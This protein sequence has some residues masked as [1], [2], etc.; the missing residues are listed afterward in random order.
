MHFQLRPSGRDLVGLDAAFGVALPLGLRSPL[1]S[2][3]LGQA[4][5]WALELAPPKSRRASP[6]LSRR[7][8]TW[9]TA[10]SSSRVSPR[11]TSCTT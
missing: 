5:F 2:R 4:P 11:T 1:H 6:R 7:L 3:S 9:S 10:C 8:K